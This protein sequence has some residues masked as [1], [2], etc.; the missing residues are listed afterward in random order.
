MVRKSYFL[1]ILTISLLLTTST[2]FSAAL[3]EYESKSSVLSPIEKR[4]EQKPSYLEELESG[5]RDEWE[6]YSGARD[7]WEFYLTP[8][9]VKEDKGVIED[10][11]YKYAI[12]THAYLKETLDEVRRTYGKEKVIYLLPPLKGIKRMLEKAISDYHGD[13]TKMTDIVRC[14][15]IVKEQLKK[16]SIIKKLPSFF[17]SRPHFE[18]KEIKDKDK[19]TNPMKNGMRYRLLVYNVKLNKE[20]TQ[21]P[22]PIEVQLHLVPFFRV[23]DIEHVIYEVK[24]TIKGK[25]RDEKTWSREE[26]KIVSEGFKLSKEIFTRA[27]RVA[28]G[29]ATPT[30]FV[31][32]QE[33]LMTYMKS[34]YRQVEAKK[35]LGY[36][37][38][39]VQKC[40]RDI[41]EA[42]EHLFVQGEAAPPTG[43]EEK[44]GEFNDI[45]AQ[46]A[47]ESP[48]QQIP[49][50][51]QSSYAMSGPSGDSNFS[52]TIPNGP[53]ESANPILPQGPNNQKEKP[54]TKRRNFSST[55]SNGLRE[56]ENL[57]LPQKPNNQQ[58]RSQTNR[59][60]SPIFLVSVLLGALLA[61][62]SVGIKTFALGE[63]GFC[64]SNTNVSYPKGCFHEV[65][66][67]A[68]FD[69]ECETFCET[70]FIEPDS[71]L[72]NLVSKISFEK[73]QRINIFNERVSDLRNTE[74]NQCQ[75][76][77]ERESV[78]VYDFGLSWTG[79]YCRVDGVPI[80]KMLFG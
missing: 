71:M 66:C 4:Q 15:I 7:E 33:T 62:S 57:I 65:Y 68:D 67:H 73:D 24:R 60:N 19:F 44:E 70:R 75:K 27:N 13:F 51:F 26:K 1:Q 3:E 37:K 64:C 39:V 74:K 31:Q 6:F 79:P 55:I 45:V 11:V 35:E 56:S 42:T 80:T 17:R 14:S 8:E 28:R 25:K 2:L 40:I 22:I 49:P 46:A 63:N 23:K 61:V 69:K 10:I 58:E 30:P 59:R 78:T 9:T 76:R 34:V 52:S 20:I 48:N 54:Q 12:P 50:A 47:P 16:D 18:V 38:E 32:I 53:R 77:R 5:A 36:L 29:D 41:D 72:C 43:D 21:Y